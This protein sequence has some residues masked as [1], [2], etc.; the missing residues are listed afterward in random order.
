MFTCIL[1][2]HVLF[3][4]FSVECMCTIPLSCAHR[5]TVKSG[6]CAWANC[7]TQIPHPLRIYPQISH[8][9]PCTYKTTLPSLMPKFKGSFHTYFVFSHTPISTLTTVPQKIL[10]CLNTDKNISWRNE[11]RISDQQVTERNSLITA[12]LYNYITSFWCSYLRTYTC[13]N[14]LICGNYLCAGTCTAFL[15][16]IFTSQGVSLSTFSPKLTFSTIKK[17]RVWI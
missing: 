3:L 13:I 11:R 1:L 17:F 16:S 6:V 15:T 12:T 14:R 2:L 8:R 4:P 10:F 7:H 9:L 5:L